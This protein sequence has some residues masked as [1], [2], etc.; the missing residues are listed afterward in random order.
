MSVA[1][2]S[3]AGAEARGH[4]FLASSVGR[5][6]VMAATGVILFGFAT[7][8]MIGNTQAYMGAEAFNAYAKFLH[9]MLHGAGIWVFRAV[10]LA[11]AGLHIWA[12]VSLTL[13]NR[14]ARPVGYRA[15]QNQASTWASR[16]MRWSGMILAA[17]IIYHLMHLTFGNAHPAFDPSNPH[18][19]FVKGFQVPAAA[20]FYIVAQLCL[21][22]H[23]WHG[24]WSTTQ[25]LGLAHPRFDALRRSLATGLTVLVV[26]VNIS[27]PVAVLTGLIH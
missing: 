1:E 24:V 21:G 12:A 26:G 5:K 25:S 2:H 13:D 22:L 23:M 19:N 16:T 8:H 3:I 11:A 18:Q 27:F 15:Q 10:L 14:A 4:G 7:V 17:F 9:T 6:V 20:G